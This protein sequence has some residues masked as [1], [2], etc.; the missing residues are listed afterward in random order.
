MYTGPAWH[1][2]APRH[3][4]GVKT[5]VNTSSNVIKSV[6]LV[7]LAILLGEMPNIEPAGEPAGARMTTFTCTIPGSIS[8]MDNPYTNTGHG[9]A[10]HGVGIPSKWWNLPQNGGFLSIV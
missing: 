5:G 9:T 3:Q 4:T 2:W 1:L 6:N 8:R 10:K 7:V